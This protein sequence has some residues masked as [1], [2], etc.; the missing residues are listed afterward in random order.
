MTNFRGHLILGV[1]ASVVVGGGMLYTGQSMQLTGIAVSL[2]LLGSILPDIDIHSSIP[3]R[4]LGALL[5]ITVPLGAVYFGVINPNVSQFI[6]GLVV[7]STGIGA[8][9]I[10]PVGLVVLGVV[11]VGTA[12][13]LGYGVDEIL[14]HR[15]ITHTLGFGIFGGLVVGVLLRSRLSLDPITALAIGACFAVGVA[16]HVYIGDS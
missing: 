12:N 14:T 5:L 2:T 7:R 1:V 3:R 13:L 6:G 10:Q 15:G 9:L 11:G 8:D 4:W 16:V